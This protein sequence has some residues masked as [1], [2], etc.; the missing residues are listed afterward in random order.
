MKT[1]QQVNSEVTLMVEGL[2]N[3][4][5]D[6]EY[7]SAWALGATTQLLVQCQYECEVLKHQLEE[8][9]ASVRFQK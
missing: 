3:R 6:Q 9:Q 5:P 2:E 4:A 7:K 8:L 1:F